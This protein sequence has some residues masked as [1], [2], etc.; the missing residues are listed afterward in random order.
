MN[1]F[2]SALT[3]EDIEKLK[4]LFKKYNGTIPTTLFF[5]NEKF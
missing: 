4:D 2:H 1:Q 3:N 5:K